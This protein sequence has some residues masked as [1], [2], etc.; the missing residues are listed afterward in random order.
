MAE[1][2]TTSK[3]T[4]AEASTS[5]LR[6]ADNTIILSVRSP[7]PRRLASTLR[8]LPGGVAERL[9]APVL[10]TGRRLTASR[11][12]ES[13]PLRSARWQETLARSRNCGDG[14]GIA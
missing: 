10:K 12:F 7:L 9:N 5:N 11:G 3:K 1:K 8:L 6:I 2:K 13:L 4:I 14:D